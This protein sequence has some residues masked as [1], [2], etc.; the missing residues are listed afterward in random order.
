[1]QYCNKPSHRNPWNIVYKSAAGK[2]NNRQIMSTLQKTNGSHTELRETVQCIPEHLIP[3]DEAEETDHHKRIRTLIE[4]PVKT[5]DDRDFTAEE[6]KQTMKSIDYKNAPGDGITSK[7][8]LWNFERLPRLMTTLYNG[9]LRTGCFP[10]SWKR[11]RIIPITK[12]GKRTATMRP[13][14][15]Q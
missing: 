15:G 12:P 1:M 3:K 4:E 13:N 6:I 9:C 7:I 14:T 10:R 8:L 11:A 5:V 2:I